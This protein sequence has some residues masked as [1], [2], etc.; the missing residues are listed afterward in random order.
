LQIWIGILQCTDQHLARILTI[1]SARRN[2]KPIDA[3]FNALVQRC[4]IF[5]IIA[6]RSHRSVTEQSKESRLFGMLFNKDWN[7]N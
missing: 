3:G 2:P 7:R 5:R 6:T 4:E 1:N